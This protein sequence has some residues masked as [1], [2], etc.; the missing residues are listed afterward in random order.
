MSAPRLISP[1]LDG[2][3]LNDLISCHNGTA[4]YC[5]TEQNSNSHFVL[6][7]VSVPSSSVQMD[8]LLVTGAFA[9]IKEANT[10]F[11]EDA[12]ALLNEAK[13]L[14]HMT[15]LGGFVDF[16]CVQVIHSDNGCGFT[17]YLLSPWRENIVS[18][19]PK[20]NISNLE[21][22]NLALDLCSSLSTCRHAGYLYANLK[23]ENIF[24]FGQHY[25]IGDLGFI[26]LS[27]VGKT[28]L[29]EKYR[30]QYTAPELLAG[31]LPVNDTADV[32]ALG[33]IL[34]QAYNGGILPT[35][36]DIIGQLYAPPQ[37]A[38]YEMAQIILR[39]CAPDPAIRWKNPEQMGLALTRYLQ[40]NGMH[41]TPIIPPILEELSKKTTPQPEPFLPEYPEEEL[42]TSSAITHN[43]PMVRNKNTSSRTKCAQFSKFKPSKAMVVIG[44]LTFVL[45]VELILGITLLQ[46]KKPLEITDF[47]AESSAQDNSVT[48]YFTFE[49]KT[50]SY[51]VVSYT[52]GTEDS[53]IEH[54]SDSSVTISGLEP[55]AM[56]TFS[57]SCS[58]K[59]TVTG[60]SQITYRIPEIKE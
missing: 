5:V 37:Y 48:L 46:N 26:P 36:Q 32:Y 8:A 7:I 6:K 16:D 2:F 54:F 58:D 57:L 41:S 12:R 30:S 40:R 47:Y 50:P 53:Q 25:R 10:Y 28:T 45:L 60:V 13:T 23:P 4:C 14:R 38:D 17:V 22:L 19:L 44:V 49:G 31:T 20:Q 35:R 9:G 33:M 24:R 59:R 56:Y 34:Y 1:M 3:Q 29:P 39:A 18:L 43:L 55:G 15:T 11:K 27:S 52:N 51:W 21:A 42:H